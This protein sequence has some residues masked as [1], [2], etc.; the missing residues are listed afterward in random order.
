MRYLPLSLASR[1]QRCLLVGLLLIGRSPSNGDVCAQ[2]QRSGDGQRP[3]VTFRSNVNYV[4]VP[5]IVVDKQG[6]FVPG[7]RQTDFTIREDG[8]QQTI[9]TFDMVNLQRD[10]A[11][12]MPSVD[13]VVPSDV[14]SNAVPFD[15]RLYVL[16]MDDLNIAGINTEPTRQA[17]RRFVETQVGPGDLAAVVCTGGCSGASQ[18][19]TADR[20]LLVAAIDRVMGRGDVD[21][22]G[23]RQMNARSTLWTIRAIANSLAAIGRRRK[24]L[25]LFAEGLSLPTQRM[26]SERDISDAISAANRANVSIY[27]VDPSGLTLVGGRADVTIPMDGDPFGAGSIAS[28]QADL[29]ARSDVLRRLSE[30]TGGF[31]VINRNDV[32]AGLERVAQDNSQYYMLGYHPAKDTQ[33]GK[34]HRLSVKVRVPDVEVRARAGYVALTA[35]SSA[36]VVGPSSLDAS[37]QVPAAIRQVLD[38]PLPVPDLRLATWAAPFA[39]TA[40]GAAVTIVVQVDGRD[41]HFRE[42]DGRTDGALV[43]SVLATD[44]GGKVKNSLARTIRMPLRA[45]TRKQVATNGI[46][47]VEQLE[48]PAGRVRL[49]IAV[50]DVESQRVGSVHYDLDVPDFAKLPFSVSG[51]ALTSSLAGKIPNSPSDHLETFRARLAGPPTAVRVF[52]RGEVIGLTAQIYDHDT[53][54]HS[55]EI[56]ASLKNG[57]GVEVYQRTSQQTATAVAKERNT[58][59]YATTVALGTL[60]PG[61][62]VLAVE[63]HSCVNA[64]RLARREVAFKVVKRDSGD[65]R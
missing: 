30:D 14:Q 44:P 26:E 62:Y 45:D 10:H 28:M 40:S 59:Q 6:H 5:V 13:R 42:R 33:D 32:G 4:E 63:A 15:G 47:L 3:S 8:E 29:G 2:Q 31:A 23:E 11:A 36:A 34:F 41:I 18:D 65:E 21:G 57:S 60:A 48:L 50:Q 7:L 27:S 12:P 51:L 61:D 16:L 64:E 58:Y 22:G 25:V 53:D 9:S 43:L 20:R 35:N 56:I 54:L 17:A 38:L 49:R 52:R 19:L 24:A 55:V 39:S 1:R 37:N 46:R